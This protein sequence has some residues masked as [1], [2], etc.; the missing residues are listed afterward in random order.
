MAGQVPAF[1]LVTEARELD[2]GVMAEWV[3]S[4]V[5][6]LALLIGPLFFVKEED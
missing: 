4:G 6:F 5:G 1:A 2:M 3:L